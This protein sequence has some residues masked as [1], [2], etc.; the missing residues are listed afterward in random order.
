LHDISVGIFRKHNQTI[1]VKGTQIFC[2]KY[3]CSCYICPM[4]KI[5]PDGPLAQYIKN[6][7]Q[8][9]GTQSELAAAWGVQQ[10]TVSQYGDGARPGV[11]TAA[12]IE[13]ATNGKV[14]RKQMYPDSWQKIWPDLK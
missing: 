5:Y 14:T 6:Y 2:R 11:I 10:G 7:R 13:I 9:G 4:E 8:A 1:G 12:R 3:N